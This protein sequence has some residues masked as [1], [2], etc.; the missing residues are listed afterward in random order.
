K[1]E[2]AISRRDRFMTAF[3]SIL[4]VLLV[5]TAAR[6]EDWPQWLGP[7]RDGVWRETGLLDKFPEGGPKVLWRVPVSG[8]YSGPAVAEGRV[9]ATDSV[10]DGQRVNN[11]GARS[12]LK[13]VERVL[14]FNA[15]DGKP[16]W[17]HAYDCPYR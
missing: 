11:P 2:A 7:K 5:T 10:T 4:V 9:Y 12:D 15:T 16:I 1:P 6:A 17:K 8:G 3:K 14:C 13:S